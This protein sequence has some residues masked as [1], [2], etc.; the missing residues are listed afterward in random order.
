MFGLWQ[1]MPHNVCKLSAAAASNSA[2]EPKS[3]HV[4]RVP[5]PQVL[6]PGYR[7]TWAESVSQLLV[8]LL[9]ACGLEAQQLSGF[10]KAGGS[11]SVAPGDRIASHNHSWCEGHDAATP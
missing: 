10:W 7:G 4:I 5:T 3:A 1:G 6:L 8:S 9:Q 2:P 11:C